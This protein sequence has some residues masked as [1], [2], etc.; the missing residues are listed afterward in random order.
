MLAA[1]LASLGVAHMSETVASG[2]I[3]LA[4][5]AP[6]ANL[7]EVSGTQALAAVQELKRLVRVEVRAIA[8][9]PPPGSPLKRVWR[10]D[11]QRAS[12]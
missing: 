12:A 5:L 6:G 11:T 1:R 9:S 10:N 8:H 7:G 2:A 4:L 3:G